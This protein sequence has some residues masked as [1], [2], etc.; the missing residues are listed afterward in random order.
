MENS[1]LHCVIWSCVLTM[2]SAGIVEA[3]QNRIPPTGY[4]S[5]PKSGSA[6]NG[7]VLIDIQAKDTVGIQNVQILIDGSPTF[8]SLEKNAPYTCN[9]DTRKVKDGPHLLS[10]IIR[11]TGNH[12]ITTATVSVMVQNL[13]VIV[14]PTSGRPGT[15]LIERNKV[16][17]AGSS[18]MGILPTIAQCPS[19][20]NY[21]VSTGYGEAKDC[22]KTDIFSNLDC[23][24]IRE[25]EMAAARPVQLELDK[26]AN[27][28]RQTKQKMPQEIYDLLRCFYEPG[29]IDEVY[30][31]T[32]YNPNGRKVMQDS[33]IVGAIAG[34]FA[35]GFL[36]PL[37]PIA[38]G[39]VGGLSA[40]VGW[41]DIALMEGMAAITVNPD[42]IVFKDTPWSI[43]PATGTKGYTAPQIVLWAHEL[44][45]IRQ[46][47]QLGVR[48]F[49][50]MYTH[51]G[52]TMEFDAERKELQVC[53]YLASQGN[54]PVTVDTCRDKRK[55]NYESKKHLH[56]L[57]SDLGHYRANG[58]RCTEGNSCYTGQCSPFS[59]YA[60][61][62]CTS[63][64]MNCADP[65]GE[66]GRFD[67]QR[68]G[69][70][71]NVNG[72]VYTCSNPGDGPA[73]WLPRGKANGISCNSGQDCQSGACVPGMP[74]PTTG[75]STTYCR[76]QTMQCSLANSPG[77]QLGAV[78]G[79]LLQPGSAVVQ[80]YV[81][82]FVPSENRARWVSQ[83]GPKANGQPSASDCKDCQSNFCG[84]YPDGQY[85]CMARDKHCALPG[86]DGVEMGIPTPSCTIVNGQN[87]KCLQYGGWQQLACTP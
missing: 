75:I 20:Q 13:A 49:A 27:I 74:D 36:G 51:A 42:I 57:P 11:N 40:N 5:A 33:A 15:F 29:M 87:Y 38:G 72:S 16:N 83:S 47:R 46:Y 66:F 58:E 10:A 68:Y 35:L 2:L 48:G 17:G 28:A 25:Q 18:A 86:T 59:P 12:A 34:Y 84:R 70:Q 3:A 76:A 61:G 44:E 23:Q 8:C 78:T 63:W 64:A 31:S 30:F 43:D 81:C 26:S 52:G 9:W 7:T 53:D 39:V 37:G 32:Q 67:G 6:V 85:Y 14:P 22:S 50:G 82:Q 54:T 45:H 21:P 41:Q 24:R 19:L 69:T 73:T 71:I 65:R 56:P 62:Y 77:A 55:H 4:V 79:K 1:N 60:N 80:N